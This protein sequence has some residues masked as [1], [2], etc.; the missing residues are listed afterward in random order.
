[1][2]KHIG[3]LLRLGATVVNSLAGTAVLALAVHPVV[4]NILIKDVALL[5]VEL[6]DAVLA[7]GLL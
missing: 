4:A 1:M 2:N 5:G 3:V 6:R 7:V